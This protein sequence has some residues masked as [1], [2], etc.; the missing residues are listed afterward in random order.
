MLAL[1]LPT[2][3]SQAA[4]VERPIL[5][6]DTSVVAVGHPAPD[7]LFS[8]IINAPRSSARLSDF[9]GKAV[10]LDFWATWCQPC[11]SMLPRMSAFQKQFADKM[12]VILVN[13]DDENKVRHFFQQMESVSK[14]VDEPCALKAGNIFKLFGVVGLP[15]YVWIDRNGTIKAITGLEDVTEANIAAFVNNKSFIASL[16]KDDAFRKYAFNE[17]MLTGNNGDASLLEYHSVLSKYMEGAYS[18]HGMPMADQ[19]RGRRIF[20]TNVPVPVLYMMAYGGSK[21]SG[22]IPLKQVRFHISDTVKYGMHIGQQ[23]NKENSSFLHCYELIVPA[24]KKQE[25]FEYMKQDLNRL[26]PIKARL[27]QQTIKCLILKKTG[28]P[29]W[30]T[31]GGPSI[32]DQSYYW[33]VMK[34]D[35]FSDLPDV[36]NKYLQISPYPLI[37]ETGISEPVDISIK[38]KLSDIDSVREQLRPYGLTLEYGERPVDILI[39][40][41]E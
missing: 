11:V 9:R 21:Y 16:K 4:T 12:Q 23:Y 20:A 38:A 33:L 26:F 10:I 15:Q 41:Q 34:N 36:L 13:D 5:T 6:V 22:G 3:H 17:P 40:T 8:H 28:A 39:L 35:R 1:L 18:A 29:N 14:K 2:A 25:L 31:K 30:K 24:A 37:D 7:I 27:E 32:L 19:F